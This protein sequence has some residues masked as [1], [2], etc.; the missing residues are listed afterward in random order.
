MEKITSTKNN[1]IKDLLNLTKLKERNS[2]N[3]FLIEGLREISMALNAGY[4]MKEIYY[5]REVNLQP[6]AHYL[7]E[8]FELKTEVSKNVFEKL[9]YRENSDGLI[10]LAEPVH[11]S[12]DNIKLNTNPL[13][14]ILESVEKPGNLGAILRTS[15]AAGIDAL[16]ICDEVTDIYN[17]NVIRS[18]L[19]CIF[20]CQVIVCNTDDA[21]TFLNNRKIRSYAAALTATNYYHNADF[22]K[23]SAIVMGSE[24]DGLS[25]KWLERA[26]QQIKIPM[27]GK[28]DSLN[29]SAS[30]AVIVYEA[31]RQRGFS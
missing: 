4:K 8:S 1:K 18:S 20:S 26:D 25:A 9:A 14:L 7:I 10:A 5:C 16:L 24:A 19:G 27:Y 2:R 11:I 13:L 31:K 29:V 23:P 6:Q 21:I 22:T 12:L 17:P 28:A 3:L 30:A 15:D